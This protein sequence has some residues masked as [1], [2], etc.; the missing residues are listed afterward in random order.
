MSRRLMGLFGVLLLGGLVWAEA[1]EDRFEG[2]IQRVD[3]E[4]SVIT[5]DAGHLRRQVIY[6]TDTAVKY[7]KKP[8]SHE[9]IREG[10]KVL[11][12]GKFNSKVQLVA[13]SLELRDSR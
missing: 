8:A 4:G 12:R 13:T 5:V 3:R 6:S 1:K 2:I 9:E 7:R 10:Q 11:A